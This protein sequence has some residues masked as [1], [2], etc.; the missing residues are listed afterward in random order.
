[1]AGLKIDGAV[2]VET[3]AATGLLDGELDLLGRPAS[4]RADIMGRVDCID[5]EDRLV[6]VERV[7]QRLIGSDIGRLLGWR[8]LAR[9]R[10]RLAVLQPQAVQ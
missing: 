4:D 2:D 9:D 3:V 7:Q 1:M 6:G 10:L 8:K 5:K